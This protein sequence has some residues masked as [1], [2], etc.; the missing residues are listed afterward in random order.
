VERLGV[1][2]ALGMPP[3]LALAASVVAGPAAVRWYQEAAGDVDVPPTGM[4]AVRRANGNYWPQAVGRPTGPACRVAAIMA[5]SSAGVHRGAVFRRKA[6]CWPTAGAG[7]SGL[8]DRVLEWL[9][10]GPS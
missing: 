5:L 9:L 10:A 1:A 6:G 2:T 4:T 3:A 7:A 8:V